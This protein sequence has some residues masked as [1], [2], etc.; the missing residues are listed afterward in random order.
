[1]SASWGERA[2]EVREAL[3]EPD[4]VRTIT[5]RLLT[6][7]VVQRLVAIARGE[8][9]LLE[10]I[11]EEPVE[12]AEMTVVEAES[13]ETEPAEPSVEATPMVTEEVSSLEGDPLPETD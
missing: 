4:S 3:S 5:N 1:L 8:A 10:E 12:E 7:K 9:S 2:E 11:D 6:D 13:V